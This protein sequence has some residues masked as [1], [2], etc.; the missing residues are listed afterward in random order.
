M[1]YRHELKYIIST[2]SAQILK[3]YLSKIMDVDANFVGDDFTYKIRSLYFDND[4]CEA[5]YEKLNGV[6]Y[7]E[8]Y[9]IRYY[10][11]DTSFIRL[12]CKIKN[13]NLTSKKQVRISKEI[14][15]KILNNDINDIVCDG[16]LKEFLNNIKNKHLIS[17]SAG[18]WEVKD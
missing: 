10:N 13:N 8:K 16:L 14:C 4:N 12:E 7:R 17:H 18:G 11:D 6:L 15:D 9:R 5:Y 3:L 2:N 1:K